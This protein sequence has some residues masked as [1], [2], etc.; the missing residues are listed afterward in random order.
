MHDAF[1][2]R[3]RETV[4]DLPGEIE[5][6]VQAQRSV[7]ETGAQRFAFQQLRHDVRQTI[8]CAGVV[9]RHD[10]RVVQLPGRACFFFEP[11]QPV[12]AIGQRCR[13]DLDRDVAGE[14]GV[15]RAIDLA[16]AAGADRR[17]DLVRAETIA[18]RQ[19][20]GLG[21]NVSAPAPGPHPQR[22]PC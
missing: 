7:R 21:V 12:G 6:L 8:M 3:G 4:G 9:H 19:R 2:V 22:A 5:G 13:Q 16:H 17:D 18:R 10:V 11:A 1:V 15:A 14:A 20:H